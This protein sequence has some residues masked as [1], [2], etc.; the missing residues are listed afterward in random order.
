MDNA[1]HMSHANPDDAHMTPPHPVTGNPDTDAK[2]RD[3]W[4]TYLNHPTYISAQADYT[5]TLNTLQPIRD[6][7]N[8]A[9]TQAQIT[10]QQNAADAI[11]ELSTTLQTLGLSL[12]DA[13][14][15]DNE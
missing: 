1:L 12:S 6:A 7:Y 15:D 9:M 11:S 13:I 3:A 10:F 8:Q 4:V 2:I 5:H 14:E